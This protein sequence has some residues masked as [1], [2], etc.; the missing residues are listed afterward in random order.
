MPLFK[1]IAETVGFPVLGCHRGGSGTFGP[2]NTMH[3]FLKS[4]EYDCTAMA[5]D[6]QLTKDGHLVLFQDDTVERTTNGKGATTSFT[7]QEL[8]QLNAAKDYPSLSGITVPTFDEFLTEFIPQ[9]KLVF[10]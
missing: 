9:A 3:A 6:L 1:N 5:I 2:E 8:G 4:L 7:L 10:F